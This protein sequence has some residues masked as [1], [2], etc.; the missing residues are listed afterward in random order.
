VFGFTREDLTEFLPQLLEGTWVTIQLTVVSMAAALVIGLLLALCRLSP[1]RVLRAPAA[2]FVEFVRGTPLL[3]QIFYIYY[4]LPTIPGLELRLEPFPAG[5]IGL[6]LNFGAYLSEVYRA[7]IQAVPWG[8]REAAVS[9]GLSGA[10]VMRYVVL[11]QAVRI[12]IPPI[13]NYFIS[14]FKDSALTAVITIPEL[15]RMGNL[16]AAATFRHFQIYTMVALIYLAVSY[17]ASLGVQYL[18]R[19]LR[20]GPHAR[21]DVRPTWRERWRKRGRGGDGN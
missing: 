12:V 3:L 17:P 5:V 14:M 11:P 19:R 15:L 2:A 9:T 8:Q 18:E 20:V 16:L 1:A 13:G 4:V 7:G 10:A 21:V 6:S